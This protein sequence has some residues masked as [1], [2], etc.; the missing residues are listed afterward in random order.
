MYNNHFLK[1]RRT[2]LKAGAS[3]LMLPSVILSPALAATNDYGIVGKMAP[4]LEVKEWI[5]A[6]G[7]PASAFKLSDNK[8]K[9]IFMEFWQSWCPGCHSH[10]FPGLKKISDAFEDNPHFVAVSIQTTF[11]GHAINTAEKMLE[12]QKQYDLNIMMG[13]DEGDAKTHSH[14][15]TMISYRSGGTPWAVLISPKGKVI[16][17]GFSINPESAIDV[18]AKEIKKMGVK[19]S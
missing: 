9:F 1:K 2:L 7:K 5:D 8:G 17:N 14:P 15:K 12:I 11:E 19:N 18:L 4:E 16:F 6:E 13:H 3:A 10:G